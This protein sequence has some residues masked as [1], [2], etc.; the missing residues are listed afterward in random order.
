[1]HRVDSTRFTADAHA[2]NIVGFMNATCNVRHHVGVSMGEPTMTRMIK[3]DKIKSMNKYFAYLHPSNVLPFVINSI[4][5]SRSH[6]R[7]VAFMTRVLHI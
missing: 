2:G 7:H 4:R 5:A 3:V 6:V 1:M